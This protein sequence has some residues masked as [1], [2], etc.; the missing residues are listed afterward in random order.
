M[1]GEGRLLGGKEHNTGEQGA[2]N[3]LCQLIFC[4]YNV[5]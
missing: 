5:H 1:K 3:S 4:M 2:A